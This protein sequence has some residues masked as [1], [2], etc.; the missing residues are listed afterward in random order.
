MITQDNTAPM[1]E[2]DDAAVQLIEEA[3]QLGIVDFWIMREQEFSQLIRCCRVALP[4]G[5]VG[6]PVSDRKFLFGEGS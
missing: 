2:R 3:A 1:A 5:M 4:S 6:A